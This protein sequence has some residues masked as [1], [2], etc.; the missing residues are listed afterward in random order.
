MLDLS[1]YNFVFIDLNKELQSMEESEFQVATSNAETNVTS[2]NNSSEEMKLYSGTTLCKSKY[3]INHLLN[4]NTKLPPTI[5]STQGGCG[6]LL[7]C[8]GANTPS[9]TETYE[10][11]N[12]GDISPELGLNMIGDGFCDDFLNNAAC[13]FDMGDCC[14]EDQDDVSFCTECTCHMT[15]T[16]S[17]TGVTQNPDIEGCVGLEHASGD[18]H[19]D[20]YC[21]DFLNHEACDFDGGDCCLEPIQTAFCTTCF[22]LETVQRKMTI[23]FH[24]SFFFCSISAYFPL[25]NPDTC[26]DQLWIGDMICDDENNNLH[27]HFDGGDCCLGE[28]TLTDYCV[29]CVCKDGKYKTLFFSK[30]Q[31]NC[32]PLQR[33]ALLTLTMN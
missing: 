12:Y 1:N 29:E 3:A 26:G 6:S 7:K 25:V 14:N 9:I 15:S 20:G 31:N 11:C 18:I 23:A 16:T 4:T 13:S 19:G 21:D 17:P 32:I 27:C 5:A 8:G 30:N 10:E 28:T 2:M 22:C 33:M 24:P